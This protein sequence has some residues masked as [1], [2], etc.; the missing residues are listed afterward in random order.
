MSID[1][2]LAGSVRQ[3]R[4]SKIMQDADDIKRA[5]SWLKNRALSS[6]TASTKNQT[7][8]YNMIDVEVYTVLSY[9]LSN[10]RVWVQSF[11]TFDDQADRC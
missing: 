1:P 5:D 7:I 4:S 6:T 10:N 3:T 2:H 8:W 11:K 9:D